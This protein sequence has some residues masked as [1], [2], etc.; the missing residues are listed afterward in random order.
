MHCV[1]MLHDA[2][3]YLKKTIDILNKQGYNVSLYRNGNAFLF[4]KKVPNANEIL[5]NFTKLLSVNEGY[6]FGIN[7]Y[8]DKQDDDDYELI[9]PPP[10]SSNN[11]KQ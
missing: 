1:R 2:I 3:N 9:Y 4:D 10:K 5:N 7:T 8:I 6:V 11:Y